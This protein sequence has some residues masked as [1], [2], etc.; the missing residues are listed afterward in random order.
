MKSCE[1]GHCLSQGSRLKS[2]YGLSGF[3]CNTLSSI[4][5][6]FPFCLPPQIQCLFHVTK[7]L[8]HIVANTFAAEGATAKLARIPFFLCPL[9]FHGEKVLS[10]CRSQQPQLPSLFLI[11]GRTSSFPEKKH[12]PASLE[13][14]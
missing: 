7:H 8:S 9:Q 12:C 2:S 5:T 11:K 4:Q 6:R 13:D 3:W 10:H 14:I 1:S